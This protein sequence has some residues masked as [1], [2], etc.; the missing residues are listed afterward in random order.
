MYGLP[1]DGCIEND[2]LKNDL[3][4]T[5]FMSAN[6]IPDCRHTTPIP[7]YLHLSSTTLG[8]NTLMQKIFKHSSISLKNVTKLQLIGVAPPIV[9]LLSTSGTT[10]ITTLTL[11]S[12]NIS[13]LLHRLQHPPPIKPHHSTHHAPS[14]FCLSA[15]ANPTNDQSPPF[16][17]HGKNKWNTL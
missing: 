8:S 3:H 15:Q 6:T 11:E 1:Q 17:K 12:Q 4:L 7:F 16:N 10:P 14:C 5:G 9:V 13:K 2:L